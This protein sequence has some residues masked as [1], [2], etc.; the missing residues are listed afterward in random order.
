MAGRMDMCTPLN[1][2]IRLDPKRAALSGWWLV[3][4]AVS[5]F[6]RLSPYVQPIFI[7]Q[8]AKKGDAGAIAAVSACLEDADWVQKAAVKALAQI[9]EKGTPAQ[10]PR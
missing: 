10:S 5:K 7:A 2:D 3:S 9:A 4:S 1:L 8:I 6:S